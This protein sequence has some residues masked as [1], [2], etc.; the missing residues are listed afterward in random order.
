MRRRTFVGA[1]GTSALAT[2]SG[3]LSPTTLGSEATPEPSTRREADGLTAVVDDVSYAGT[4]S[5]DESV[6]GS[7]DCEDAT[8]TLAGR[9]STSSCRTVA[10]S[11]L[12]VDPEA[13]SARLVVYPKWDEER[14]P[15]EID[16]AG[17]TYEYRIR[18]EA[19]DE[20]PDGVKVVHERPDGDDPLRLSLA[21]DC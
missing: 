2:P 12:S 18:L 5:G 14:S 3:C 10:I 8:A 15:A 16:C 19:T 13:G 1:V 6:T 17:A 7:F 20:L 9:L 4:A 11:E 21:S